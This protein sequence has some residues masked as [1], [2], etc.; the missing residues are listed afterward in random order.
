MNDKVIGEEKI[1][2]ILKFNPETKLVK[3]HESKLL[4]LNKI[5]I[6]IIKK[7]ILK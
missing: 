1:K 2:K 3:T 4:N 6:L 5:L 7:N